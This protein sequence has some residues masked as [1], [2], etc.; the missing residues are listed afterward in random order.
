[1]DETGHGAVTVVVVSGTV[2]VVGGCVV[3]VVGAW[4]VVVVGRVVVVV[5]R[6]VDV[7]D[8]VVVVDDV[9]VVVAGA[10]SL[11]EATSAH[12]PSPMATRARM[13][14]ATINAVREPP[15]TSLPGTIGAVLRVHSVP[16]Q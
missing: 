8:E 11:V 10:L 9:V 13:T 6:V 3:V 14:T 15:G 16:S 5:G 4:V 7:V 12:A 2:V 1:V